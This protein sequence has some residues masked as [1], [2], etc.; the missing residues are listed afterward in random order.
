MKKKILSLLNIS[1]LASILS[2][3]FVILVLALSIRGQTGNPTTTDL[4]SNEWL[5]DGPFEVSPERGRFA[6]TYS[7]IEDKSFFFQIPLARFTAPDLGYLNDKY[8]S[9]FAPGVSVIVIP[10]FIVG[11]ALG[12][13]QVGTFAVISLF[14]FF[15]FLLVKKILQYFNLNEKIAT[16][17]GFTFLFATPAF[18]YAVTL[19]QHHI[20]TFLI[21]FSIYL[22]IRFK[23][24]WITYFIVWFLCAASVAI[25]NPNLFLMLPVGIYSFIT[26]FKTN[27]LQNEMEISFKPAMLLTFLGIIAPVVLFGLF[28]YYSYGNP[29]QLSGTVPSIA[30]IG[31]DGKP[32]VT[33]EIDETLLDIYLNP[34]SQ[35]KYVLEIFEPRDIVNGMYILL[36]SPDR[37]IIKFTPVMLLGLVGIYV[38]YKRDDKY[39]SLLFGTA[40]MNLV[41]YSMWGDPWGGW[42]FGAR[43]L[44]P[45]YAIMAIFIGFAIEKYY[46]NSVFVLAFAVLLT[47]SV[48][49][50]TLGALTTNAIPPKVQALPLEA[51]TNR[52]ERYSYDR[53]WEF[54]EAG[55]SKSVFFKEFASDYLKARTYYYGV[56]GAILGYS[57]LLMTSAYLSK[58]HVKRKIK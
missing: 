10:G 12:Y 29:F 14:A 17:A 36:L 54:I 33:E 56:S 3:L 15:N 22:L 50:N 18:A 16:L 57:F 4:L 7:L 5:R 13:S 52:V 45:M 46:K 32:A 11:K 51:L 20:S 48:F 31:D 34:E 26:L 23:D 43:Y 37:G 41:L 47:Y 39:L 44:I 1:N 19:Y 9:L 49:V 2:L 6:L 35:E 8:V 25:D 42:A 40:I 30:A 53:S 58:E 55:N 28:N 21:L 27:K 24:K 38:L